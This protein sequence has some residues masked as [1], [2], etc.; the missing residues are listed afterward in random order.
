MKRPGWSGAML[1]VLW[2]LVFAT[3]PALAAPLKAAKP[4]VDLRQHP[5][6]GTTPVEV[7]VGLYITN[8][9]GIDETRENFEVGGSRRNGWILASRC[10]RTRLMRKPRRA[11]FD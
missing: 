9:V 2:V 10:P 11:P 5:T 7:G 4:G 1:A 8:F 6:G 3:T